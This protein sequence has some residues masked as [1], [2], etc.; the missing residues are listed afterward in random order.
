[1]KRIDLGALH[2]LPG[3]RVEEQAQQPPDH[4]DRAALSYPGSSVPEHS[5]RTA[6]LGS[7]LHSAPNLSDLHI[8]RPKL[9]KPP[10]DPLGA[11]FG[12][13]PASP[14]QPPHVLQSCRP[15]RGSPKLPDFLQRNPLPPILGSPTKVTG[16]SSSRW[17]ANVHF[18]PAPVSTGHRPPNP[19]AVPSVPSLAGGCVP[20]TEAGPQSHSICSVALSRASVPTL[21]PCPTAPGRPGHHHWETVQSVSW[22][23]RDGTRTCSH[24]ALLP[25]GRGPTCVCVHTRVCPACVAVPSG[26]EWC[27]RGV[28]AVGLWA[29]FALSTPASPRPCRRSTSPRR[30][31]PRTC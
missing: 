13:P 14:P 31:A 4:S 8:V 6:G 10:T 2:T 15:L 9:P 3:G 21:A 27:G 18:F 17:W 20:G 25:C 22:T 5:P 30:P 19:E 16:P 24:P 28:G 29:G 12:H 11:V 23:Q 1:M 7:R 26:P